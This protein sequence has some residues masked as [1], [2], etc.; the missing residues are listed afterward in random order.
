MDARSTSP[1]AAP[2]ASEPRSRATASNRVGSG[3]SSSS[4]AERKNAVNDTGTVRSKK[5]MTVYDEAV[6][7]VQQWNEALNGQDI[8]VLR[9]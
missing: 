7:R 4:R 8:S 3:G 9:V 5:P 1:T 6:Q 2:K